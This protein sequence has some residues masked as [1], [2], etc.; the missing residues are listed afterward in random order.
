MSSFV[1]IR[2]I[3]KEFKLPD[4]SKNLVLKNIDL[5]INPGEFVSLIG[6][7]GCGKSTLLN[8]VAGLDK[9]TQGCVQVDGQLVRRPWLGSDDGVSEL[10]PLTLVNCLG[11]CCLSCQ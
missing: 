2:G 11:Q 6:H 3:E 8:I 10:F 7:S 4:G 9:P 5:D 1:E